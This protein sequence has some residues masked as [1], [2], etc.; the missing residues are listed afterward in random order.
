MSVHRCPVCYGRGLVSSGFYSPLGEMPMTTSL[1]EQPCRSCQNG[2]IIC[3]D[4]ILQEAPPPVG[5]VTVVPLG[6]E[7]TSGSNQW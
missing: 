5:E 1:L 2:V 7:I 4:I 3:P 6:V